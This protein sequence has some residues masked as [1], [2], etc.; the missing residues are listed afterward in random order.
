MPMALLSLITLSLST[1]VSSLSTCR[2]ETLLKNKTVP[3]LLKSLHSSLV[4][5]TPQTNKKCWLHER[6]RGKEKDGF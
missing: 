2:G 1:Q 4:T 6:K 3:V 5:K